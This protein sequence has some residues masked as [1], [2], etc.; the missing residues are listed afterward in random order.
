MKL[1]IDRRG[2]D[3]NKSDRECKTVKVIVVHIVHSNT[4]DSLFINVGCEH[5]NFP[6]HPPIISRLSQR[7][8]G[9]M[10]RKL[11]SFLLEWGWE[12]GALGGC[13]EDLA[14]ASSFTGKIISC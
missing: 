4:L 8:K 2:P 7:M 11:S 9:A 3:I 14:E 1:L 13:S 5:H 12:V 6:I 10:A